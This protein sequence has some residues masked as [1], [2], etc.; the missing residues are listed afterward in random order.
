MSEN[1]IKQ[2]SDIKEFLLRQKNNELKVKKFEEKIRR[3][4]ENEKRAR[5]EMQGHRR[6]RK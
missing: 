4:T 2:Q 3:I 6:Y 5:K 1:K